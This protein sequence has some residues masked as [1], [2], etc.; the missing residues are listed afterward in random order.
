MVAFPKYESY[1]DSGVEWLG[2]I[3]SNWDLIKVSHS[4][5][6]IGSGTTPQSGIAKYYENGE[7]PWVNTGDL[8][9]SFLKSASKFLTR[10][11]L[12][13]HSTLKM[14]PAGTVLMAMYGAT[15]GKAAILDFEACTNQ[16]CCA[17]GNSKIHIP[18]FG[19][20]WLLG[21]RKNIISKSYGGGQPNISQEVIKAL[22]IS[23]PPIAEQKRIVEFLDRKTSEIDQA[24]AKKQRLI[25]LLQ[26]QKVILINQAVTKG[27]N[28]NASRRDS[29]IEWLG[30]IPECWEVNRLKRLFS[31]ADERSTDGSETLLSLRM[32]EGL[33][34]HNE[35]SDKPI[36]DSDLVGYKRVKPGELVMNRMRAAIGLFGVAST[37]GIVSPDYAIF[38]KIAEIEVDYYLHLFKTDS[39][40]TVFF[41]ESK[42]IGTGSSGFLRL[43][44]DRF[45]MVKVP[46][47]PVEEQREIL[48]YIQK[49]NE[50]FS[51][52][53]EKVR[54]EI[55]LLEELKSIFIANAVTG[56][57]K[58]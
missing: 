51:L 20:Y 17:L 24:I 44:S 11:A 38:H 10:S 43:Y 50:E 56:K 3:P 8:N 21:N 19:F 47:P 37:L 45:G 46:V 7:I 26:E 55:Q 6:L 25:E 54:Y 29:G 31:E 16:A 41:L 32:Y 49:I 30:E 27:L 57:L 14:Y 33:I 22:R 28:P 39:L 1:K 42:G 53:I 58:V 12:K 36:Q 15:I 5:K 9:D 35:V 18:K 48:S 40:K 13:D 4:F 23:T 52:A 34:P 2:E